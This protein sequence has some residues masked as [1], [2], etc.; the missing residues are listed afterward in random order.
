MIER[1]QIYRSLFAGGFDKEENCGQIICLFD[2]S[3]GLFSPD[4]L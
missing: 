4:F 1:L 3:M 2:V